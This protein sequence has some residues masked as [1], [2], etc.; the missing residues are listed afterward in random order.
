MR[1]TEMLGLVP[2]DVAA[3]IGS[4]GKTTLL[5]QLARENCDRQVLVSTTT[6]MR[7]AEVERLAAM[8]GDGRT[9]FAPTVLHGDYAGEKITAP[10]MARL[11]VASADAALTLLECDGSKGRPFKGWADY[12]PVV[13]D[14]VTVTIGVMPLWALGLPVGETYVHRVEQFCRI[15]GAVP[16]KAVTRRHIEAVAQ[17]PAGLFRRAVGRRVLFLSGDTPEVIKL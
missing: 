3:I 13:P 15:S 16:G 7:R 5:L 11:M 6:K 1:Y 9:Q 2:G 14:F 17:H 4:G 12:E 10:S 8:E